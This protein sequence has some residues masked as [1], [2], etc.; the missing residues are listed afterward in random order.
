MKKVV[1][2]LVNAALDKLQSL[3]ILKLGNGTFTSM[4][5][6]RISFCKG[7]SNVTGNS[8]SLYVYI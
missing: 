7:L 4:Q 6:Y 1:V 8:Q 5:L 2:L 3:Y